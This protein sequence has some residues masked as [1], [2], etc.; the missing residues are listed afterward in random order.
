[1]QRG[2]RIDQATQLD[3]TP[4]LLTLLDVPP[5]AD[6]P[7]S[8]L[9]EALTERELPARVATYETTPGPAVAGQSGDAAVDPQ[10]LERLKALG[11]L[12]TESPQGDRNMAAM[13]FEG[14]QFERSA[15]A[16]AALVAA[17]PEDG[18][19]RASLAGALASLSRYDEALEHLGEAIRLQPVNPEAHHNRGAIYER[20]EKPEAAV[21]EYRQALRYNP[22]Y[23]PS[24]RALAR[25][26][27]TPADDGP[28]TPAEQL[29]AKMAERA[30][31]AARRGDYTQAM[32]A[33]DE[34][35]RVAP[36]Y[37]RVQQ[38][39]ANV[40]YLM[41]D[42]DAARTALEKGLELDPGNHLFRANLDRLEEKQRAA[43][44]E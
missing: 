37:A 2:R 18:G 21:E 44:S 39:R 4:T 5:A 32:K 8:V 1:V 30:S 13:L 27:A 42:Y 7:G 12:D 19:L 31:E 28:K 24:Q 9:R 16:Y 6:M 41:G 35:E 40:A 29:A 22:G 26:G 17:A 10:V 36:G 3:V 20:Q 23:E 43:P 34:A 14:G 25:L 11:Y 33:L 38:Y 15:E